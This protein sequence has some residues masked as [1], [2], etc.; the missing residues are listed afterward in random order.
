LK[1]LKENTVDKLDQKKDVILDAAMQCLAR[2]GI[3]K[4]TLD[5]I[6]RLVGVNKATLYY[7]YKNKEAIFMDAMER[8]AHVFLA[9]ARQN[10]KKNFSAKNKIYSFLRTYHKY[11]HDRAEI[12]EL[13]AQAM[14]DSHSFMRNVYKH[15]REKNIDFMREIIQEGIDKG[16]FRRV[17]AARVADILRHIL[18]LRRLEFFLDSME[19]VNAQPDLL[20]LEKDS[21]YILD[22]FLNGLVRKK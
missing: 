11:L 13:N 1:I 6:A 5:D 16:E 17:E 4:T 2:F 15:L 3:V 14:V 21:I 18:D 22:I 20:Q 7:Y 12:L 10:F 19:K 9:M 8:E